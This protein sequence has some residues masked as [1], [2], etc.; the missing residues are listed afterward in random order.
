MIVY[1]SWLI[2]ILFFAI[3]VIAENKFLNADLVQLISAFLAMVMTIVGAKVLPVPVKAF[4]RKL[5][6]F[7]FRKKKDND[8]INP[9]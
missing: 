9:C 5:I 2:T 4:L 6:V 3:T 8:D 7:I 1:L